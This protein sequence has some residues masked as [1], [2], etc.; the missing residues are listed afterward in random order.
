MILSQDLYLVY[1][2][3]DPVLRYVHI[4]WVQVDVS[5]GGGCNSRY[6]DSKSLPSGK[7]C[8][9]LLISIICV[10][11][12]TKEMGQIITTLIKSC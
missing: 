12:A 11:K 9:T 1:T 3:K 2:C 6:P 10:G 4:L 5:V 7:G 8:K